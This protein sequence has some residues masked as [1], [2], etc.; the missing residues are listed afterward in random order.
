VERSYSSRETSRVRMRRPIEEWSSSE[1]AHRKGVDGGDARIESGA[2]EGLRR[3]KAS[4]AD[5]WVVGGRVCS[6]RAWTDETNDARGRKIRQVGS[7]SV[8]KG[9]GGEGPGGVGAVWRR[10]GRE[11]GRQGV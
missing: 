1:G 9:S 5:A 10:G 11:R 6:T 4:E 2:E 3:W 8:L 7:G